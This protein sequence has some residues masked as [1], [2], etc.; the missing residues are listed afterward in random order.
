[1]AVSSTPRVNR[2]CIM[3][4]LIAWYLAIRAS[5]FSIR[6]SRVVRILAILRCSGEAEEDQGFDCDPIE[7]RDYSYSSSCP[8]SLQKTG[9]GSAGHLTRKRGNCRHVLGVPRMSG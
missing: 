1:M 5:V 2:S 4:C 7:V 6:L 8:D 9:F 3:P